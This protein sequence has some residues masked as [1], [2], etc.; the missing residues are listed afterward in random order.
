MR[1]GGWLWTLAAALAVGAGLAWLIGRYPW[2][3]AD[4]MEVIRLVSLLGFLVLIG[5]GVL[6]HVRA[7]PGTALRQAGIWIAIGLALLLG[8]SYRE[9]LAGLRARLAGELLPQQG[10]AVGENA[11]AFRAGAHGHFEVEARVGGVPVL[12]LVDTG[13]SE[14]VLS[15]ADARRLGYDPERLS[16]TRLYRTANG[17]VRGAPIRLAA[18]EI[19]AIRV[20]DVAA[21]VNEAPMGRSLLGMTFLGRLSGYE[22]RGDTLTL[23]Q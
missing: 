16:Y 18:I 15:P 3:L 7:R 1:S 5:G 13:A 8:Y 4:R 10:M 6:W 21:S 9:E 14:V 23:R 2:A 12:F 17:V 20:A 19:G 11:M 22:V